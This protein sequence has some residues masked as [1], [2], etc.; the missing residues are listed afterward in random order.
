M[1]QPLAFL[2]D[3]SLWPLSLYL[4]EIHLDQ[5]GLYTAKAQAA[6]TAS[7]S[8]PSSMRTA[9]FMEFQNTT[10]NGKVCTG[11]H[12]KNHALFAGRFLS[13]SGSPGTVRHHHQ[14]L[15]AGAVSGTSEQRSRRI[16]NLE[17]PADQVQAVQY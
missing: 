4:P 3:K 17:I 13:Y 10:K 2:E 6:G 5:A 8:W 9:I 7:R 15:R 11:K 1:E 12:K 16:Y 14:P